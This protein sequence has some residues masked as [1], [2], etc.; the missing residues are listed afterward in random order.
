[1]SSKN[2]QVYRLILGNSKN[3]GTF[4]EVYE[5][6]LQENTN[7]IT[8]VAVKVLKSRWLESEDLMNRLKDEALLLDQLQHPNI[9]RVFGLAEIDGRPAVIMELVDG[10]DLKELLKQHSIPTNI[11]FDIGL[12]VADA[13]DAAYRQI[14]GNSKEPHRVVHRDIK[15][16]NV[17]L[18]RRG[19]VKVLDFG[20]SRFQHPDRRGKTTVMQFGSPKYMAPERKQGDR[21]QHPSDIYSLGILLI[22]MLRGKLLAKPP[23]SDQKTHERFIQNHINSI[24]FNLPNEE[25]TNRA[26][27]MLTRMCAYWKEH[28]LTARKW[29]PLLQAFAENSRGSTKEVFIQQYLNVIIQRQIANSGALSGR[30][31]TVVL[32]AKTDKKSRPTDTTQ[33]PIKQS[34]QK[35]QQALHKGKFTLGVF[36]SAAITFGSLVGATAIVQPDLLFTKDEKPAQKQKTDTTKSP[37]PDTKPPVTSTETVRLQ[38]NIDSE[39]S[40]RWIRVKN[41][42]QEVVLKAALRNPQESAEI[43][44]GKYQL[45]VKYGRES[46]NVPLE[47]KQNT[48]INCER[49]RKAHVCIDQN[50]KSLF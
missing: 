27:E 19:E 18:N 41:Q 12:R 14:R 35:T 49:K 3:S 1:M 13:L 45:E 46:R 22:E 47:I 7:S 11:A 31:F 26:K 15:P 8:P 25:W 36:L 37:Q 38:I 43:P 2:A 6:H 5:G 28:R 42:Q 23:P 21:G 29:K 44:K 39:S 20:A 48:T 10:I 24:N 17:M 16:S 34:S 32:K 33:L 30:E 40:F 4:A 50:G 9:I